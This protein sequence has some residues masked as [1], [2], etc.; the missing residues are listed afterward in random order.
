MMQAPFTVEAKRSPRT[1]LHQLGNSLVRLEL[2]I[3]ATIFIALLAAFIA[4][5]LSSMTKS[6]SMILDSTTI[7]KLNSINTT[8]DSFGDQR[9]IKGNDDSAN[10]LDVRDFPEPNLP[11]SVERTRVVLFLLDGLRFDALYRNPSLHSLL[12]ED[13][14]ARDSAVWVVRRYLSDVQSFK[15]E[16]PLPSISLPSWIT[17]LTGSSPQYHGRSGEI[18][19]IRRLTVQEI[20]PRRNASR[21]TFSVRPK[22]MGYAPPSREITT[23]RS[24]L[25][26]P[27]S[28]YLGTAQ[29]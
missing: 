28:L 1:E 23:G 20:T 7:S 27:F 5:D 6:N 16:V 15:M 11:N 13:E 24:Y 3:V 22:I 12:T 19:A 14:F 9:Y 8:R 4:L 25:H 18:S 21:T 2:P 29:G 17:T 26:L 10:R